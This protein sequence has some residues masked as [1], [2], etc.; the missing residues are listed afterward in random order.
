MTLQFQSKKQ[1]KNVKVLSDVISLVSLFL[2][3]VSIC[4]METTCRSF[5]Q[6]IQEKE[7]WRSVFYRTWPMSTIDENEIPS[8]WKTLMA[9]NYVPDIFSSRPS[10]QY[11]VVREDIK[12]GTCYDANG[13]LLAVGEGPLV[14]IYNMDQSF[15]KSYDHVLP[16]SENVSCI[17]VS[18]SPSS[19]SV[20]PFHRQ[21][22][23]VGDETG[24]VWVWDTVYDGQPIFFGRH[25]EKKPII[26]VHLTAEGRL[27]SVDI[28]GHAKLWGLHTEWCLAEILGHKKKGKDDETFENHAENSMTDKERETN[29]SAEGNGRLLL[30]NGE[31]LRLWSYGEPGMPVKSVK[32]PSRCLFHDAV[33]LPSSILLARSAEVLR[34]KPVD[35]GRLMLIE[36]ESGEVKLSRPIEGHVINCLQVWEGWHI[37]GIVDGEWVGM[38]DLITGRRTAKLPLS[39]AQY[40]WGGNNKQ[41]Y[42]IVQDDE[43]FN[44]VF[45]VR[46]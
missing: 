1:D 44:S 8:S 37:I 22:V 23:A 40:A 5:R 33:M 28:S 30:V 9:Q 7:V 43:G 29:A 14:H 4:R 38:W 32:S 6:Q 16:H 41:L 39:G 27:V 19:G 10:F 34:G 31:K 36:P 46:K 15:D 42:V 35:S 24:G 17:C 11:A 21:H 18:P 26:R 3:V 13:S 12:S 2:D 25:H 20:V 45:S